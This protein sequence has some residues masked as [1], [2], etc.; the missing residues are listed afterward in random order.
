[1]GALR[2]FHKHW[3]RLQALRAGRDGVA[4]IEFS[5]VALPFFFLL[6]VILETGY[7]FLLTILLNGAAVEG[8]RQVRTGQ[9]QQEPTPAESLAA[10]KKRVCDTVYLI[11][12]SDLIFDV[13]SFTDFPSIANAPIPATQNDATFNPGVRGSTVVVTRSLLFASPSIEPPAMERSPGLESI[14]PMFRWYEHPK[15]V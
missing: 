15:S 12:C 1:M 14:R 5:M 9:I 13:Q 7:F 8:A 6:F 10:L 2:R 4:A 11:P 3:Q